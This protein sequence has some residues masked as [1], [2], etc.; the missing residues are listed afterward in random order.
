MTIQ[1]NAAADV[2]SEI[3]QIER[4]IMSAIKGKDTAALEPMLADEFVYRTHFGVE[5]DKAAFLE[6][7]A[8]FPIEIIS[9]AWRGTESERL[10]RNGSANRRANR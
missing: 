5:A 4:D 1:A 7:I 6:S 2:P 10:W 9:L 3:L 8:S